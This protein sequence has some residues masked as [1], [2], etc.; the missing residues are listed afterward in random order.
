[1][2]QDIETEKT[3]RNIVY[4]AVRT[5]LAVNFCAEHRAPSQEHFTSLGIYISFGVPHY[6]LCLNSVTMAIF[7]Q[8]Q[9]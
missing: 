5:L 6:M 8:R 9:R 2:R 7:V 4:Y 3:E 1:M